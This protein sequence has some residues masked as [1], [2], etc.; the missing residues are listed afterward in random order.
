[1]NFFISHQEES[2]VRNIFKQHITSNVS[3]FMDR[4]PNNEEL[5]INP[6]N[7]IVVNE[8][9]EYFGLHD[10]VIQNKNL[11]TYILTWNYRILNNCSNAHYI[12]FG[13]SW[14]LPE[15]YNIDRDKIFKVSHLSGKL[16]LSY[17][18][19]MRHELLARQNEIKIP[20][21]FYY[22]IGDR[23][24]IPNARLGKEQVFGESAFGICIENFSHKSFFTEKI[25]D[26]FLMKTIPVYWGCSDLDVFFDPK[27]II[28]F[29]NVDDCIV[30]LN[31]LTPEYYVDRMEIIEKNYELAKNYLGFTQRIYNKM[32]EL[33]IFNN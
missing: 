22:T 28:K 8:P 3:L 12:A 2:Y 33:N 23:H 19:H 21:D 9:N 1:M 5:S 27:G 14:F 13:D 11:F 32:V 31:Q 24:D 30:K 26:C 29:E 17:G 16:K 10:W 15:Q 20:K 7:V 25:I 4:K 6:I 18:H